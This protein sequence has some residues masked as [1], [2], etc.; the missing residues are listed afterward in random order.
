LHHPD[1][2]QD[3]RAWDQKA[4]GLDLVEWGNATLLVFICGNQKTDGFGALAMFNGSLS[5]YMH[6]L[7]EG[8]DLE[9]A[10]Q[11]KVVGQRMKTLHRTPMAEGSVRGGRAM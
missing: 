1:G 10:T 9:A 8:E 7:F 11:T 3:T 6:T 4:S 2:S 5:E